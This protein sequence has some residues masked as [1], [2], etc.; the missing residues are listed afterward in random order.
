MLRGTL[1]SHGEHART[2]KISCSKQRPRY[3]KN[4]DTKRLVDTSLDHHVRECSSSLA[5]SAVHHRSRNTLLTTLSRSSTTPRS[6][7]S[8]VL[9][10]RLARRPII[11]GVGDA[12]GVP[13]RQGF[14]TSSTPFLLGDRIGVGGSVQYFDSPIYKR[15]ALGLNVAGRILRSVSVGVGVSALNLSYN[16]DEFVGVEPGDP[17]FEGGTNKTT[18][19]VSAGIFAKPI[20]NL[21]V[22]LGVRN[23]NQPNLL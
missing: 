10:W 19:S 22:A 14:F 20:P 5:S 9:K 2:T 11:W 3:E 17:V 4:A 18:F 16:R 8:S 23:L 13:L 15:G 12:S 21:N 7:P 6:S 1:R